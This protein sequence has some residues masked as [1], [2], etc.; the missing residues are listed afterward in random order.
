MKKNVVNNYQDIDW[1]RCHIDLLNLQQQLVRAYKAKDKNKV[2]NL[3]RQIVTSFAARA[4]AVRRVTLNKGG[5]TPGVDGEKWPT[6]KSRMEAIKQLN[7]TTQNP[8][9][10]RA[11]PVRRMEIPKPGQAEKRPLGIPTL[12][13]RAVQAVYLSSIDPIAEETGDENSFGFR[14]YRGAREAI[15]KLN[16]LLGRDHSP[17]W[18]YDAD[19]RKC[20]D[21]INHQWLLD[22]VPIGDKAVL[23]SWLKSGVETLSGL[24]ATTSG[25]P[26]GGVISPA[27]CSP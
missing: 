26:Q 17:T 7:Y 10:Y 3:Q 4:L 24:E 25:V 16:T 19:I 6:P 22:N 23:E 8:N 14:P 21:T 18:I 13:D 1:Q 2:L 15:T 12:I 27:L 5:K 11:Q 9:L 20:F